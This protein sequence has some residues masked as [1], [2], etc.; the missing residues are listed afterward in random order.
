MVG[1]VNV[2]SLW[3][4]VGAVPHAL[5]QSGIRDYQRTGALRRPCLNVTAFGSNRRVWGGLEL[6]TCLHRRGSDARD[7]SH[8][9]ISSRQHCSGGRLATPDP[10]RP[11]YC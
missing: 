8:D 10:Q 3:G 6:A 2:E 1:R 7:L 9:E 4:G 5:T 11:T